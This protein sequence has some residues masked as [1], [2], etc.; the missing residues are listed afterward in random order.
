MVVYHC[1]RG[2]KYVKREGEGGDINI[3]HGVNECS[4]FQSL[5]STYM[6]VHMCTPPATSPKDE[7]SM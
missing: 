3:Y 6:G 4:S 1:V 5:P 7:L 2:G